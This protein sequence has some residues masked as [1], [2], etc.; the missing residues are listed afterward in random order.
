M[1][2]YSPFETNPDS[3]K[4]STAKG[5]SSVV[6]ISEYSILESRRN[7]SRSVSLVR[8]FLGIV[9]GG[10][11]NRAKAAALLAINLSNSIGAFLDESA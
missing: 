9:L 10:K 1:N 5:A 2:K 3:E 6:A 11:R 7:L 4:V 8:G